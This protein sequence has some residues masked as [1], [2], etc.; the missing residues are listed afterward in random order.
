MEKHKMTF[1]TF[2]WRVTSSHMITYFIMGIIASILLDYQKAFETPPLSYFMRP[3]DSPW[4]AAGPMLQVIRGLIFS[5][6]LWISKDIFLFKK[7]GWLKL[8]G[9][10]AGLSIL[11]TTGPAL[12]SVEGMIYTKIPLVYHLKAYLEVVPQTLSFSLFLFYWYRKPKKIWNIVS[13]TLMS[14]IVFFC[15]MGFLAAS[16]IINIARMPNNVYNP[17]LVND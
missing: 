15:I 13:I 10:L 2:F 4:V 11:S 12:G 8:W 3:T 9:L 6:V 16:E 14:I 17:L 5:I 1:G 7:Y